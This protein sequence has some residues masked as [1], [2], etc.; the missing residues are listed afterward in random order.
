MEEG[1]FYVQLDGR[2]FQSLSQGGIAYVLTFTMTIRMI[3]KVHG[4][5]RGMNGSLD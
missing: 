3:D 4:E 2:V 5:V 1:Q